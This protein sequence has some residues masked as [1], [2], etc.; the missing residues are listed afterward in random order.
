MS[1]LDCGNCKGD[2]DLYFCPAKNEFIIREKTVV[3][4]R[5]TRWKKEILIMNSTAVNSGKTGKNR[6]LANNI[7]DTVPTVS[8]YY[9]VVAHYSK[10]WQVEGFASLRCLLTSS[11]VRISPVPND[12]PCLGR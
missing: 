3:R 9:R 10:E 2:A 4:E 1:C 12:V 7:S 5:A 8:F 6:K 11:R